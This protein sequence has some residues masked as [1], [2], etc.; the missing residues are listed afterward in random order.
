MN[1]STQ[2]SFNTSINE[3]EYDYYDYE[4]DSSIYVKM[5]VRFI[6]SVIVYAL[7]FLLGVIGE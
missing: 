6:P 7:T 2:N 5:I 3:T 1:D 4:I